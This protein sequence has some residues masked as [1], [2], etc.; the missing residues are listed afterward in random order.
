MVTQ[1][2]S[3]PLKDGTVVKILNSGYKRARIA[4]YRGPLGPK[5]ARVYRVLV[6]KKP[7]RVY[8]EVLEDQLEVLGDA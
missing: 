5:G 8:I 2:L 1:N 6:Q 4:E 7:R 3:E